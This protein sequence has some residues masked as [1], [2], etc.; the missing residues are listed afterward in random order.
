[1]HELP[2]PLPKELTTIVPA[3]LSA[4]AKMSYAQ[5][6]KVIEFYYLIDFIHL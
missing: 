3:P 2:L 4:S 6:L 1:V 5:A